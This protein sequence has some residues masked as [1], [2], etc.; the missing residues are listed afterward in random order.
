[1]FVIL[2]LKV[3]HEYWIW[4]RLRVGGPGYPGPVCQEG[5]ACPGSMLPPQVPGDREGVAELG[6]CN[7]KPGLFLTACSLAAQCVC[8]PWA[9]RCRRTIWSS[10][11][12]TQECMGCRPCGHTARHLVCPMDPVLLGHPP[13][14]TR[15]R[16]LRLP[17]HST[18]VGPELRNTAQR[19]AREKVQLRRQ[20]P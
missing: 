7:D 17:P 5:Q 13:D 19:A 18:H 8:F 12:A 2:C 16:P 11:P 4:R 6:S 14:P 9:K 10:Y 20:S 3:A 15:T 1:M